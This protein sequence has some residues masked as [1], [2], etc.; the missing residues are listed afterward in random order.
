MAGFNT[1]VAY[2]KMFNEVDPVVLEPKKDDLLGRTMFQVNYT[3]NKWAN[4]WTWT[5]KERMGQAS[6]Y[7]NRAVDAVTTTDVTY[8]EE[9]GYITEKSASFEYSEEDLERASEGHYDEVTDKAGATHDALAD[10]EDRVIF[11]GIDDSKRPIYGLTFDPAKAGYQTMKD[12]DKAPVTLQHVVDPANTDSY[13]DAFKLINWF[14]DAAAKITLL[15][16]YHNVKP[17]LALPSREYNL[18][19]RPLMNQYTPDRTLWG[20]I[21]ST[22]NGNQPTF[23][24]I[25]CVPE[26]DAQYWNTQTGKAGKRNMGIVYLD[27]PD[28]ARI[29]IAMEP[30]R[31]GSPEPHD[32]KYKQFYMERMG[33]LDL[34]FPAGI[35]QLDGLNDG[36]ETWAKAMPN[37][38][39]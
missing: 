30:Q 17:T 27:T 39:K 9:I 6:D 1:N 36:S 18:I 38:S 14:K 37:S 3:K 20:M 12:D 28:V 2:S 15:P 16:G 31:I 4:T 34:R 11:N 5:W 21:Q 19:T 25:K 26:L 7:A 10:W 8:H 13:A 35:V 29:K 23:A 22:E 24:D 32:M 33:G